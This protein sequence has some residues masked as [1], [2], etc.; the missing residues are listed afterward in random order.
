MVT[1]IMMVE[2]QRNITCG[3]DPFNYLKSTLKGL[4]FQ[5]EPGQDV[6][7]LLLKEKFPFG[8]EVYEGLARTSKFKL[9]D[10]QENNGEIA[11]ILR[12][13]Q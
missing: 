13:T 8:R 5:L 6:K 11:V 2:D 9:V 4:A 1:L 10:L 7:V 12:K 3:G